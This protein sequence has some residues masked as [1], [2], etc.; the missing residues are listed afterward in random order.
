MIVK[1][2]NGETDIIDIPMNSDSLLIKANL[3]HPIAF[4]PCLNMKNILETNINSNCTTIAN[5]N[6]TLKKETSDSSGGS[7]SLKKHLESDYNTIITNY[8][9]GCQDHKKLEEKRQN[10]NFL[11]ATEMVMDEYIKQTEIEC[12]TKNYL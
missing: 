2:L 12:G 5:L 7:N 6:D 9:I 3:E 10:E 4:M 8:S 11:K 1:N